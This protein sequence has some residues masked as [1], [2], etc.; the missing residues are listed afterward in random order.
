MCF[1]TLRH[2]ANH[3]YLF[4]LSILRKKNWLHRRFRHRS[5]RTLK[6]LFPS[7]FR[8]LDVESFHSEVC[9]LAKHKC[10]TFS[11]SNKRSSEPFHL[12]RSEIWG[13]SL[14]LNISKAHW[15]VFFIDDC[16]KVS[17]IFLL[18][19]KSYVSF[20]LPNFRNMIKNQFSVAIKRFRSDNAKDYFKLH[21]FIMKV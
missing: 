12:I 3:P 14:V 20:I 8:K 2:Q 11:I 7:M 10:L 18:K 17:W 13:P 21:T 19:H 5:F 15:F 1:I 6:I 9:E 4:F 16:T